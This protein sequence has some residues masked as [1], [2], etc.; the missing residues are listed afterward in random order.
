MSFVQFLLQGSDGR[1]GARP[2]Y[3]TDAVWQ[4]VDGL[5]KMIWEETLEDVTFEPEFVSSRN[6]VSRSTSQ[7]ALK[8]SKMKEN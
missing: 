2:Y 6:G 5:K 4:D 3:W 8:L 7:F 1:S